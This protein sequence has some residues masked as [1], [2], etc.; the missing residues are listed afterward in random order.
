MNEA[1]GPAMAPYAVDG[2][3]KENW[4]E[5]ASNRRPACDALADPAHDLPAD[6][7][8]QAECAADKVCD[9]LRAYG[10]RLPIGPKAPAVIPPP[11]ALHNLA[12]EVL[13]ALNDLIGVTKRSVSRRIYPARQGSQCPRRSRRN[14]GGSGLSKSIDQA[15]SGTSEVNDRVER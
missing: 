9:Q 4:I 12:A 6:L 10:E 11:R 15:R 2:W 14:R 5:Y 1:T 13:K 3:A 7:G 8:E